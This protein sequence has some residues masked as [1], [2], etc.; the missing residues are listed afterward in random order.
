LEYLKVEETK[1]G[2]IIKEP[3][4]GYEIDLLDRTFEFAILVLE[5]LQTIGYEKEK[6][7]VRYQLA[8]SGTSVGVPTCRERGTRSKLEKRLFK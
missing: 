3:I 8:K 7:V 2:W 4:N 5:T 1:S 6:D